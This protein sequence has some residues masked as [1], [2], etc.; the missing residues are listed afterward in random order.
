MPR[1]PSEGN[2]CQAN[3]DAEEDHLAGS[4]AENLRHEDAAEDWRHESAEGRAQS[5]GDSHAE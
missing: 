2:A 5:E 4:C 3:E 1:E